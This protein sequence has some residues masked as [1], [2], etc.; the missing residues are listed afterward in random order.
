MTFGEVGGLFW[1]HLSVVA[2]GLWKGMVG[3]RCKSVWAWDAAWLENKGFYTVKLPSW[4]LLML[5]IYCTSTKFTV[6]QPSC[7]HPTV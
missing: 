6:T 4:T 5:N 7:L 3:V 2:R 1:G